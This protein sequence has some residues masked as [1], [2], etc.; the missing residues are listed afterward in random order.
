VPERLQVVA[1]LEEAPTAPAVVDDLAQ[2]VGVPAAGGDALEP[3]AIAHGTTF[4][5]RLLTGRSRGYQTPRPP[6]G[7]DTPRRSARPRPSKC[8]VKSRI[9]AGAGIPEYWIVD[10]EERCVEILRDPDAEAGMY[11]TSSK[12]APGEELRSSAV[13]GVAVTVADLFA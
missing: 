8:L 4:G 9:Y 13:D 2:A 10:L 3:G 12:A 1:H 7:P 5:T 6:A 11:R